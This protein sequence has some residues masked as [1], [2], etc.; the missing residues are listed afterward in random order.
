MFYVPVGTPS[1]GSSDSGD[2]VVPSSQA[3][4]LYGLLDEQKKRRIAAATLTVTSKKSFCFCLS[5]TSAV[6]KQGS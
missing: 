3:R 4:C 5:V 2:G 6:P 1:G